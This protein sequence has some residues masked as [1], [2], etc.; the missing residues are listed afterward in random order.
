MS[1]IVYK[2]ILPIYFEEVHKG[3]KDFELRKDE[4]NIQVGD[5][6]VLNEYFE[7]CY[8][9]QYIAKDVKYV[10]RNCPQYGLMEGYCIIGL[11]ET[12]ICKLNKNLSR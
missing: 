2:K 10:L 3:N 7:G 9:G 5:R 4:D 11:G 1:K 8:T 6:L 12:M